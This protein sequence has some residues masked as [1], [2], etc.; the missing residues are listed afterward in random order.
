MVGSRGRK[1]QPQNFLVIFFYWNM[2]VWYKSCLMNHNQNYPS[3][4]T[5]NTI[6]VSHDVN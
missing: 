5:L 4:V 2:L 3:R 1:D 6:L